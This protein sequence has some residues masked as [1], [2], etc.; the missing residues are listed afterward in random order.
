[1]QQLESL[2]TPAQFAEAQRMALEW[3]VEHPQKNDI[4]PDADE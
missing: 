4:G 2:S 3:L 1:L